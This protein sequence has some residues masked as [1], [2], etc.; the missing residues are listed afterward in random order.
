[1]SKS[2]NLP[3]YISA[4]AMILVIFPAFFLTRYAGEVGRYTGSVIY[5]LVAIWGV[6]EFLTALKFTKA[7][8]II[9]AIMAIVPFFILPLGP[10]K[11]IYK[12]DDQDFAINLKKLL[13]WIPFVYILGISFIP[14]AYE[15][16]KM[17]DSGKMFTR[18]MAI[19]F[20]LL[21]VATFLKTL[22]ITNTTNIATV[23][24]FIGIAII[25]DTMGFFGGMLFGKKWFN[26]KKLAPK[27]SP[28]KTWAGFVVGFFFSTIFAIV[29]GYYGK[30]WALIHV[31]QWLISV[32]MA[33][34][35][36]AVSPLGDLLFSAIKRQE[37][38][39]DF[40]NL[41]PGHG[42]IFD[43]IDAMSLVT[44]ISSIIFITFT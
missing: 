30:I 10:L 23:F 26:G 15:F 20:S 2:K 39:K 7:A 31:N 43:R 40:S 14:M 21:I 8:S 32:V 5:M 11:E 12:Y 35:L 37:D 33:L 44:F 6:F 9:T 36:S 28:K 18:Q 13:T 4:I 42:G 24:F 25:S 38:I 27:I 17:K 1:M 29:L 34:I 3:R 41:I 16:R 22:F 19:T